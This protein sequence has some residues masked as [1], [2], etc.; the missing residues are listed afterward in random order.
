M[1]RRRFDRAR[2]LAGA[3]LCLPLWLGACSTAE[4]RPDAATSEPA[5][6]GPDVTLSLASL[7]PAVELTAVPFHPQ[8]EYHCGPAALAT[9]LGHVGVEVDPQALAREVYVPRRKGT[10]QL[11]LLASAR[12]YDMVA[13]G[14][15]PDFNDL[16][17]EI[18][19]GNPVL[20][21]QN[22]SLESMPQWHYA[23]AVGYDLER[24]ELILRSGKER[25]WVTSFDVFDRTWIRGSRWAMV[26]LPPDRLPATARPLPYLE[27][28]YALEATGRRQAA[29]RAYETVVQEWPDQ[30]IAWIGLG[31]MRYALGDPAGAEQAL[32]GLLERDPQY[33]AAWNNLAFMLGQRGCADDARKAASCAVR[34]AP[35]Q[36]L[37]RN[38]LNEVGKKRASASCAPI[39]CPR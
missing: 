34:L 2:L 37:Y 27:A 18:A 12:A 10:L 9:V 8:E 4:R 32:R 21:F 31:N 7:P 16:L 1:S 30:S 5:G 39:H 17:T 13:Y 35:D 28:A 25:R 15:E 22:L 14:L 38:T 26:V 23:V 29:A 24:R 20:V 19:A 3:L 11:E 36:P 33:H 6:A